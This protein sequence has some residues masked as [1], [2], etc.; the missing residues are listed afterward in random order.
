MNEK[1]INEQ[2]LCIKV[3]DIEVSALEEKS[4]LKV[5]KKLQLMIQMKKE[6]RLRKINELSQELEAAQSLKQTE[7]D[8]IRYV[9]K[10]LLDQTAEIEK[11]KVRNRVRRRNSRSCSKIQE[12]SGEMKSWIP[13]LRVKNSRR[14][15]SIISS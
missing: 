10:K 6:E 14:C 11:I 15:R 4:N 7:G 1:I 2:A 3:K 8:R 12:P 5:E 9:E 13:V